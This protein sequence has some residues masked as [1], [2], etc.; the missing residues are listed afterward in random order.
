MPEATNDPT[1]QA[2]GAVLGRVPS[3]VFILTASDGQGKETGMLASW[4]QQAGFDPP[5]DTVAVNQ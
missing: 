3:G 1:T 5:C 2:I 4:V